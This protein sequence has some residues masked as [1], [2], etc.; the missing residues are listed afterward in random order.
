MA[1]I[2]RPIP[3]AGFAVAV[4]Q[5]RSFFRLFGILP[6]SS[7]NDLSCRLTLYADG[8]EV[9]ILRTQ[10]HSYSAILVA[11]YLPE[12]FWRRAQVVLKVADQHTT[13]FLRFPSEAL[14][15]DLLCFFHEQGIPLSASAQQQ[16]RI[17]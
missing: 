9:K 13:Y 11:D 4:E 17:A 16:I 12:R 8:W 7:R 2:P 3:A 14:T 6:G 15:R 10:R 1:L 5:I